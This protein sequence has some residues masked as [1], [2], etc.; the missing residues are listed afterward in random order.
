MCLPTSSIILCFIILSFSF[1]VPWVT[2]VPRCTTNIPFLVGLH[3]AFC[4]RVAFI[5]PREVGRMRVVPWINN[6]HEL[7]ARLPSRGAMKAP[8]EQ[9]SA[10]LLCASAPQWLNP[11]PGTS[12]KKVYHRVTEAQGRRTERRG[13]RGSTP[14]CPPFLTHECPPRQRNNYYFPIVFLSAS[15][16]SGATVSLADL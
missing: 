7:R 16:I 11:L 5:A 4:L 6:R 8:E 3:N 10:C 15:T 13:G 14:I 2:G 1:W 12:S 9:T